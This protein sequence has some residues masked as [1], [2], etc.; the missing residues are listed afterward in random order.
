MNDFP[1]VPLD[2]DRPYDQIR[3]LYIH[4]EPELMAALRAGDRRGA[5]KIINHILVHIYSAG[6]EHSELLKGLLLELVVMM[7]RAAVEAGASQTEVLG[8]HFKHL[9]ELAVIEDDEALAAWLRAAFERICSVLERCDREQGDSPPRLALAMAFMR[10]NLGRDLGREEV[11][12]RA[13]LSP[14]HF[15]Q[16]LR[17]ATGRSFSELLRQFRVQAAC[18][19]LRDRE[20]P[21]ADIATTCGFC[22]QSHFT[23]VFKEMRGVTPRQFRE[24]GQPEG[25]GTEGMHDV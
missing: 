24:Q 3:G 19:M 18:G 16:L 10:D 25:G 11:A 23:K 21:L 8:L 17:E 2:A 22:D 12:R 4:R 5:R 13:G 15:A 1:Q 20:R 9:T 6:E 14:G 7:A